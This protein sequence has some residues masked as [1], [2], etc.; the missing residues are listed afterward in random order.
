MSDIAD[1][2]QSQIDLDLQAAIYQTRSR[3]AMR[4]MSQCHFCEEF[5]CDTELFCNVDCRNDYE[6][7]ERIGKIRGCV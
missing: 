4:R 5:V 2:A 3:P 7:H 1:R 6:R